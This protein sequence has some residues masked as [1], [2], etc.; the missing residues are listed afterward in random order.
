MHSQF[1]PSHLENSRESKKKVISLPV[2]FK[3]NITLIIQ[4]LT[5]GIPGYHLWSSPFKID[6]MH[7]T[8]H[9][10]LFASQNKRPHWANCSLSNCLMV[11]RTS[12][13]LNSLNKCDNVNRL[14]D[15]L[16]WLFCQSSLCSCISSKGNIAWD[17]Q[18]K[19]MGPEH[20]QQLGRCHSLGNQR[21]YPSQQGIGL[22]LRIACFS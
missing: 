17:G 13:F 2:D 19:Q 9:Y 8:R 21:K 3:G 22:Q 5:A 4:K 14:T 20:L 12:F 7:S 10:C 16:L 6:C 15:S 18:H 1:K 11:N